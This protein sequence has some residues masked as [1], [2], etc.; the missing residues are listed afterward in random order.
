MTKKVAVIGASGMI[1]SRFVDLASTKLDLISLD[2]K[3]LDITNKDLVQKYFSENKFDA[4][5][6]FAAFTNVDGAEADKGDEEGLT[7]RLNVL[8]PKNLAEV[9]NEHDIFLIHIS[10]DFV[11]TGT[12]ESPGPYGEDSPLPQTPEG[13]GWY[14]WT[15]NRAE[16]MLM[17]TSNNYAVIRYGYPFRADNFEAK[18]DWARNLIKIY[19]EQKLYPLF[20]DQIQSIL[21]IDELVEPLVKIINEELQGVFHIAS[22]DTT[23]PYEVGKYMLE[24]YSGKQVDIQKGSMV[25][26]LKVPGRTPRPRLGGL[27]SIK[28]QN[29]LNLRFRTCR[30]MI[31]DFISQLIS[32]L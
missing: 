26:F 17:N 21:F 11:F 1:A 32:N 15:K 6:N 18:L 7:Y 28:T 25:E 8:G 2:E 14:G 4:V 10:T 20:T 24:K 3:T 29:I 5:L 13:M 31:D 27:K 22:T 23:T 12:E 9:C 16:F 19:N 30:E